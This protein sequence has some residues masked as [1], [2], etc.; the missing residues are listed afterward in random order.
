LSFW[1]IIADVG[2]KNQ[3]YLWFEYREV[4][5]E[6]VFV[7]ICQRS[8]LV[9]Y[10]GAADR[11]WSC[12]DRPCYF[13]RRVVGKNESHLL[14]ASGAAESAPSSRG[15]GRDKD[16]SGRCGSWFWPR[17]GSRRTTRA[18]ERARARAERGEVGGAPRVGGPDPA[19]R[20]R[21][22]AERGGGAPRAGEPGRAGRAR[23]RACGRACP[24]GLTE[25]RSGR[26][27]TGGFEFTAPTE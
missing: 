2:F 4:N 19:G 24:G 12:S 18:G 26:A 16:G 7:W 11:L 9:A 6:C 21:A 8:N 3:Q 20:A 14:G 23:V 15:L 10:Y 5:G 1:R 17:P 25:Q 13:S 22:R 27:W